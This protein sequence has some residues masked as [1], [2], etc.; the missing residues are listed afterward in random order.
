MR[1]KEG[2]YRLSNRILEKTRSDGK[3][4]LKLGANEE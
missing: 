4:K 1:K 3:I 2:Y